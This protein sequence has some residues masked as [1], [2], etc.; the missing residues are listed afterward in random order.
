[1]LCLLLLLG[2][3]GKYMH[4]RGHCEQYFIDA[5]LLR[6]NKIKHRTDPVIPDTTFSPHFRLMYIT[7]SHIKQFLQNV[8]VEVLKCHRLNSLDHSMFTMSIS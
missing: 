3:H 5:I 7:I 8:S 4:Q 2:T 1:M 6:S